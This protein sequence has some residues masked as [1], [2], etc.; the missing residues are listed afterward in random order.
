MD[1]RQV[2][3]PRNQIVEP[4]TVIYTSPDGSWS[5]ATFGWKER[6]DMSDDEASFVLGMRWN[7]DIEDENA[8]GYPTLGYGNPGWFVVPEELGGPIRALV[9]LHERQRELGP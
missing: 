1:P 5:L 9:Q 2:H 6:T 8:R 4:I 7:G 3:G